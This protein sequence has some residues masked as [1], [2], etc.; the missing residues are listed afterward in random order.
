M[1]TEFQLSNVHSKIGFFASVL[2][3]EP[4]N[5][6]AKTYDAEP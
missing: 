4:R 3:L 2:E 5:V 6:A 1:L